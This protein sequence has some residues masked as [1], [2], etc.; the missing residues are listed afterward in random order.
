MC[1]PTFSASPPLR[2]TWSTL[3]A[4]LGLCVWLSF[5]AAWAAPTVELPSS[6][7][8]VK[9]RIGQGEANIALSQHWE[10]GIFAAP[11]P[12][13]AIASDPEAIWARPAATF[14]HRLN[15]RMWLNPDER[16]VTRISLISQTVNGSLHLDTHAP[17][18]DAVHLAYRWNGGPWVR[19]VAGDTIAMQHWPLRSTAP[20]FL[21]GRQ[22]GQLDVVAEFAHVGAVDTR[23]TLHDPVD[24]D[25]RG[26]QTALVVGLL[27]GICLVMAVSGVWGAWSFGRPGF[28]VTSLLGLAGLGAVTIH[29]GVLPIYVMTGSENFSDEAKVVINTLWSAITPMAVAVL[30]STKS[31]APAVWRATWVWL[32]LLL[33][34]GV[35]LRSHELRTIALPFG[36]VHTLMTLLFCLALCALTALRSKQGLEFWSVTSMLLFFAGLLAPLLSYMGLFDSS[37]VFLVSASILMIG[38]LALFQA[39]VLQYRMGRMAR[40]RAQVAATRDALT[41]LLNRGGFDKRFEREV[42]NA[43]ISQHGGCAFLYLELGA[44]LQA[45]HRQYGV[46]GVETGMVQVSAA[47]ASSFSAV[48]ALGRV[49]PHAFAVAI[50]GCPSAQMAL[51]QAQRLLTLLMKLAAQAAPIA[52]DARITVAWL[53]SAVVSLAELER[54]SARALAALTGGKRIAQLDD[55]TV[56]AATAAAEKPLAQAIRQLQRDMLGPDTEAHTAFAPT[57]VAADPPLSQGV[58]GGAAQTQR[59]AEKGQSLYS[60]PQPKI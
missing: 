25:A 33:I 29:S 38:T 58:G 6:F 17:R 5:G 52:Q 39:L 40:A 14:N 50:P 16:Y 9:S 22:I 53:N 35:F 59:S 10:G 1:P 51:V 18:T 36:I 12:N 15:Q 28:L 27:A 32:S 30:F 34:S 46:E 8:H 2:S 26:L 31:Y 43:Y 11:S 24:G 42:E 19:A 23:V 57:D 20:S 60:R 13:G 37:Q 41:G 3:L 21:I 4:L 54:S 45:L 49:A 48:D 56:A 55:S 44:D 47:L 7:G